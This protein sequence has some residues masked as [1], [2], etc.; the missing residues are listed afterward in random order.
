MNKIALLSLWCI[1]NS[2]PVTAFLSPAR[3]VSHTRPT[4]SAPLSSSTDTRKPTSDEPKTARSKSPRFEWTK[5][6]YPILPANSV[7]QGKDPLSVTVLNKQLVVWKTDDEERTISVLEDSCPHR[8]APLSTGKV[9]GNTLMCRYH[10]WE[11]NGKGS[12]EKIPMMKEGQNTK[13]KAFCANSYPVS[14]RDGLVWVYMDPQSFN[15][16]SPPPLPAVSREDNTNGDSTWVAMVWPVSFQSMI[17]NS[18]DPSHAPFTH[19]G[20]GRGPFSYSPDK[21][22]PMEIYRFVGGGDISVDGFTLEHSPYMGQAPINATALS[23]ATRKFVP[24]G[25][26]ITTSPTFN[27][28]IHFIPISPQE[29]MTITKFNIPTPGSVKKIVEFRPLKR[30]VEFLSD[31]AHFLF[32]S[33]ATSYRFASQDRINMQGQD[34]RKLKYGNWDDMTPTASDMGVV[35]LQRWFKTFGSFG[36]FPMNSLRPQEG[37]QLSLWDHHAKYCPQCQRTIRRISG[38]DQLSRRISRVS[39]AACA[40]TLFLSA[41]LLISSS[42]MKATMLAS[43]SFLFLS[44]A[45]RYLSQWCK[46]LVESV[47]VNPDLLARRKMIKVYAD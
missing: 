31:T 16:D 14:V 42:A 20:I 27:A 30:I 18:F 41:R 45:M 22:I 12:C 5:Q 8:R 24:P 29:T 39:L 13:S 37:R 25:T 17:E 26:S 2:L 10:G 44:V 40:M 32:F 3:T 38:L 36:P 34:S 33:S 47:F 1:T 6:W 19:E 15:P 7:L 46:R 4:L 43:A 11:F 28:D 23:L 21:A 35:A 9:A